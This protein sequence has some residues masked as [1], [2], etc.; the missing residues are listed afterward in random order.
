[1]ALHIEVGNMIV[2]RVV[3]RCSA[4]QLTKWLE[5]LSL[6][7]GLT[8]AMNTF[9]R[10]PQASKSTAEQSVAQTTSQSPQTASINA[11]SE[12]TTKS[13]DAQIKVHVNLV[14]VRAVVRDAAGK[15]VA[16]LKKED[17]KLLDNGKEQTITTFNAETAESPR[18]NNAAPM[19]E[20]TSKSANSTDTKTNADSNGTGSVAGP[21]PQR[22]VALVLDDLHMK[23][24]ES[25]AVRAAVERLFANLPVTDRAAIY[26]TSGEVQQDFTGDTEN[27]RKTLAKIVPRAGRG[28]GEFECPNITYYMADL[29]YNKRDTEALTAA[30]QESQ[31]N[32]CLLTANDILANAQRILQAGDQNTRT[33]Y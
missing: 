31:T 14:L 22:F 28:E 8:F 4:L 17:F 1:M 21:I 3:G 6:L 2:W 15:E 12:I 25:L 27:L 23:A 33:G 19:I 13:T 10:V 20:A 24:N 30:L 26:S 32:N 11:E 18:T 29:I 5:S 7:C 16:G 9:G